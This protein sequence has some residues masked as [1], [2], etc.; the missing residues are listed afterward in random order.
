MNP[1]SKSKVLVFI[2]SPLKWNNTDRAGIPTS[3]RSNYMRGLN[4]RFFLRPEVEE[5]VQ[6][7]SVEDIQVIRSLTTSFQYIHM[8]IE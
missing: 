3:V 6:E 4:P 5:S 1:T 8:I 2:I 7:L